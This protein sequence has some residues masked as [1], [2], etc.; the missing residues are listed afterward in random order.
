MYKLKELPVRSRF[1]YEKYH[2]ILIGP[3]TRLYCSGYI[4][5]AVRIYDGELV[6]INMDADVELV[7]STEISD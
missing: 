6:N 4:Y 2:Y 7:T 5:N 3:I 1:T